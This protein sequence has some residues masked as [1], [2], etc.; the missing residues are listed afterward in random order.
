[1]KIRSQIAP[2]NLFIILF[3]VAAMHLVAIVASSVNLPYMDEWE[4]LTGSALSP[5]LNWSWVFMPH[6][7]HRIVPTKILTWILY[8]STGWHHIA[9][10]VFNFF[11]YL[12]ELCVFVWMLRAAGSPGT[13]R[14]KR[15]LSPAEFIWCLLGLSGL[16][17]ENHSW[18]FQSQ[19]HFFLLFYFVAV[20]TAVRRDRWFWLSGICAVASAFSFSS[21][22]VCAATV[23]ALLT[24]RAWTGF[25]PWAR[26]IPQIGIIGTGLAAW[27]VGYQKNANHPE[28]SWPWGQAF[29][30][31]HLTM[32]G[33]GWSVPGNLKI[34]VAAIVLTLLVIHFALILARPP[35]GRGKREIEAAINLGFAG[36][37]LL[38]AA[39]LTSFARAGFGVGQAESSRYT[40]VTFFILP[41]AWTAMT[42][43]PETGIAG[44]LTKRQKSV[45]TMVSL[46]FIC[47]CFAPMFAFTRVYKWHKAY[48][49]AGRECV[50]RYYAGT[51]PDDQIC[52]TL[53]IAPLGPQLERAKEL[54]LAFTAEYRIN[55]GVTP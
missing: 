50:A 44:Y 15:N 30:N 21:G 40:E 55:R 38:A 19:F 34:P 47:W 8:K 3:V 28:Y 16:A 6:N 39:A 42:R 7:E 48:L 18:G 33:N 23:A 11:L 41:L 5:D 24:C 26:A 2:V 31:H 36:A 35:A 52:G 43:D 22:V 32:L 14:G 37:G 46:L 1:M 9:N 25:T 13:A 29:W 20:T 10:L 49:Q 17:W 12:T 51:L 4:A 45:I 54:D 27:S 53:Y